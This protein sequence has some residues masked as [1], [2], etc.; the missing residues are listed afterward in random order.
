[1]NWIP[2]RVVLLAIVLPLIVWPLGTGRAEDDAKSRAEL[3]RALTNVKATLQDG[4]TLA[5]V[6]GKPISSKFEI[7][8]GNLQ[9]SVYT[10]KEDRFT[11]VVIDPKT[12][13]IEKSEQITDREDLEDATG[14]KAAMDKAKTSLIAAANNAVKSNSGY[15]AVSAFPTMK[16]GHPVADIT[17]V[18]GSTF[19]TVSEK[20]D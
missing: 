11:E 18:R 10:V 17:L 15:R 14:Q 13:K 6:D 16:S 3:A 4:L 12:G 2:V 5:Q 8:G 19:R 1:M 20:L 7:E 9:L